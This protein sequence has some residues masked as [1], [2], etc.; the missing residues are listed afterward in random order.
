[1]VEL[2][3]NLS[4]VADMSLAEYLTRIDQATVLLYSALQADSECL[5]SLVDVPQKQRL[6]DLERELGLVQKGLER[7]NLEVLGQRDKAHE[8]FMERWR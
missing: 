6:I 4:A 2:L 8:R 3:Q 7:I 5:L 1:M